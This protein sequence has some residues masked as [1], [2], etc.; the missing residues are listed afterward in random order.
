M[1]HCLGGA[2]GKKDNLAKI[3][4]WQEVWNFNVGI[5]IEINNILI[6]KM[7][8]KKYGKIIHISSSYS[9]NGSIRNE[10]YG[11]LLYTHV[12]RPFLICT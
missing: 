6:P 1:I 11:G 5:G 3:E 12:Q 8:A 9:I 10:P 4:D 2:L 7:K